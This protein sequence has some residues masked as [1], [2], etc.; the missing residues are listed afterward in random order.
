MGTIVSRLKHELVEAIPPAVFFFVAFH[1]IAFTRALMLEQHGIRV[2]TFMAATI[3]ALIVA[4]VVLI[5]DLLPFVN[6]FPEKPLIYNVVWK[7]GIYMVAAL[8]VRYLEHLIPFVREHG[9]LALA[10][11]HL[12]DEVVW[13]HFWFVQIWLLVLFFMYCTLREFVR[14][15]GRERVVQL[16]FGSSGSHAA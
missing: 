13:P 1:V 2:S 14:A 7:T 15:V 5:V 11:R 16:F 6:R 4:K 3:A 8:L 12:L 10:N 9:D